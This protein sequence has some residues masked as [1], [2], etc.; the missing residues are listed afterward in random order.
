MSK[1]RKLYIFGEKGTGKSSLLSW[2]IKKEGNDRDGNV[3]FHFSNAGYGSSSFSNA[4]FRLRN[5]L[6]NYVEYS[7]S[8][9]D[10]YDTIIDILQ[11][12]YFDSRVFLFFDAIETFSDPLTINKL[13]ALSEKN[14]KIIVVCSGVVDYSHI[15]SDIKFQIQ[16]LNDEQIRRITLQTLGT[17]GK[18]LSDKNLKKIV[19]CPNCSNAL[20]L[21]VA[22]VQLKAYGYFLSYDS[23]L[24][25]VISASDFGELFSIIVERIENHFRDRSFGTNILYDLLALIV[26]SNNG[27]KESELQTIVNCVPVARSIFLSAIDSFTI[28][29][30]GLIRFNH[31]LIRAKVIDILEE[32]NKKYK[33][34]AA[35]LFLGY[36]L[37][38]KDDKFRL[39]SEKPFQLNILDSLDEIV[40]MLGERECFIYLYEH[41][42][43][44]LTGYISRLTSYQTSLVKKLLKS[45]CVEEY[46]IAS[47]VLC[48]AGCY[49]GAIELCNK[50]FNSL[51]CTS[52]IK[53]SDKIR[54]MGILARSQYK[55]ALNQY[56]DSI[57]T[58]DQLLSFYKQSCPNDLVGYAGFLFMQGIAFKSAGD[59]FK[60]NS[61]FEECAKIYSDNDII[62]GSSVWVD[63]LFA[64][65]CYRTGRIEDALNIS[66]KAIA[67]CVKL[68]GNFSSE[69]AWAYC[70]AWCIH[71]ALG[72]KEYATKMVWSAYNI[73]DKL[74]LGH[75]P[76][77]AWAASNA[78]TV[79]MI[80]KK[81]K[82]AERLLLFSI[83][84]NN[85]AVPIEKQPHVYSLTAYCNLAV[86]Y[87]RQQ[88]HDKAVDT[89][90]FALKHSIN[91]NGKTHSYTANILLNHGIINKKPH[92]I[93]KAIEIFQKHPSLVPDMFFAKMALSRVLLQVGNKE[94]AC[95]II[96]ECANEYFSENRETD[97][98]TYL[99]AETLEK[100][101]GEMRTEDDRFY[102][103]SNYRIF[104]THNNN[105]NSIL[106]PLI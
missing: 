86:L 103:F 61:I 71:Y 92:S 18:Q 5:Y 56:K 40:S 75:G 29:D 79:A 1:H 23:F 47:E 70:Y 42:F 3:F 6:E 80:E 41:E 68:F 100:I 37:K 78:G 67:D 63:D 93:E 106:I 24:D 99:I 19:E 73:Y 97:L 91:K 31:D 27:V 32:R 4:L 89:I 34:Y 16:P 64:D 13:F 98:I 39:Y 102:Y 9:A 104:Q 45:L 62:S 82:E 90:E 44:Y 54:C 12:N 76:Q 20:F 49:Y 43:L 83:N 33:Y 48:L 7:G 101:A 57:E 84:E 87:E 65:S 30:N 74:F 28:E 66:E 17:V 8:E 38:N 50:Y 52:D 15:Q 69:L 88:L 14:K 21:K 25:R 85:S 58:Y 96:L 35:K 95:K 26:Y 2:L 94:K 55:L 11:N 105:S 60:A 10:D 81:Y 46:A 59:M 51:S 53:A 36:Y 72:S 77:I 22:I